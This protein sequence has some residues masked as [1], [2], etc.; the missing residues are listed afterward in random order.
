MELSIRAIEKDE[1]DAVLAA[2]K[3]LHLAFREHWKESW[4]TLEEAREEVMAMFDPERI[5]LAAFDGGEL[6]GWIGGISNYDGRVW[7]LHPMAVLPERQR[8]GIGT[9]LVQEFERQVR[10]RGGLTVLLGSDDEDDMTT[11]S[12]ID[13][14]DN[15]WEHIRTIRDKKGHPFVFYQKL[16]YTIT[17]VVPDANGY[18]K[19]DI[20]MSKRVGTA[21]Q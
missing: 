9:R 10:L 14:Y 13:L 21:G 20:L 4:A 12:G 8:Q 19:P 17:G 11:L 6:V 2:A 18:G 16:G 7:E 5:I 3:V 1:T 15:T